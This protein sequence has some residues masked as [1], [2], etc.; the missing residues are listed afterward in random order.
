MRHL[1]EFRLNP[2]A[3]AT[4]G[5]PIMTCHQF[6]LIAAIVLSVIVRPAS[7]SVETL[8]ATIPTRP[9]GV[10]ASWAI[11]QGPRVDPDNPGGPSAG[12]ATPVDPD[13]QGGAPFAPPS[14]IAQYRV[15]NVTSND[16]LNIRSAPDANASIVRT[17]PPYG[18]GIR[19]TGNCAGQWCPIDYQG[20][21]GW[22]NR[23]YL[24]SE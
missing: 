3:L 4:R 18:S 11:A 15:T 12:P 5:I 8:A 24:T 1:S 16:V 21:K 17:I 23:R 22:V 14:P 10:D 20:S 6:T 2:S 9:E 7:A 13:K 19:M